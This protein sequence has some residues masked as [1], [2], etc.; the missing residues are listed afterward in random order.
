[1]GGSIILVQL[2][3]RRRS[4]SSSW[5]GHRIKPLVLRGFLGGLTI[6][7][8][9]LTLSLI[10][11]S[12][13]AF[14][15]SLSSMWTMMISCLWYKTP[16]RYGWDTLAV[17]I[18]VG[19]ILCILAPM[20]HRPVRFQEQTMG[21]LLGLLASV[22]QA[23]VNVTIQ[24]LREEDPSV[25]I[26]YSMAGSMILS[27]PGM[28]VECI[29]WVQNH[30]ETTRSEE[31]VWFWIGLLLTGM[32]SVLA[33]WL[34]TCSLQKSKDARVLHLRNL[35]IGFSLVWDRFVLHGQ[36][37][38]IQ[39]VGLTL[40]GLLLWIPKPDIEISPEADHNSLDVPPEI[41]HGSLHPLYTVYNVSENH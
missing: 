26:G 20:F 2:V 29:R 37:L 30:N 8:L 18:G 27:S 17:V 10:D 35:E 7:V 23:L 38:P 4:S 16:W 32:M 9:F 14:M 34:K 36:L 24:D 12:I 1:M 21:I 33:Q 31:S 25:I 22:L 41:E 11:L 6:V 28:V 13:A 3:C 5:L 19:G 40:M 15:F 39:W